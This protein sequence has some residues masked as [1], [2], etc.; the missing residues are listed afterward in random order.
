MIT[1]PNERLITES[2]YW[3]VLEEQNLMK[4]IFFIILHPKSLKILNEMKK[5]IFLLMISIIML[6]GCAGEQWKPVG[7]AVYSITDGVL[8]LKSGTLMYH[9]AGAAK[10]FTDFEMSGFA[11]T[12]PN[13]VAGIWFHSDPDR[14]GYEVVI[15][16]GPQDN[17]RKTG[18]LAAVRNLYKSMAKDNEWFPFT[19]TVRGKNIAIQINDRDV[20]CY[21]EPDKPYRITANSKSVLGQ[22]GFL[23]Y[24]YQGK[25]DFK[26]ISVKP[27]PADAAPSVELPKAIDEQIDPIIRLQQQ[28]FPVIDYHV[29]LKGWTME[30]AHA[31][32]MSYGINYGIAPNCGI[33][34]PITDDAGVR[35][36]VDST[37]NMPFYFGM[38]GEG[39]EWTTTFSAASRQLFDYVFTDA[40]TFI[41]HK[42][43]RT[44][45]WIPDET[46]ID[47]PVEKYMDLI[48][49]RTVT[50]LQ[51]EPIDI[52]VNPTLLPDQMQPDYDRLWTKERYEKVIKVLKDNNIAL[53]IN[54][55]YKI[56]NFAIIRAAK[57]AG[58]KITFGTNNAT[59][60]MGKLDYCLEAIKACGLTPND[61]WFPVNRRGK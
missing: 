53:E 38:Q 17:T 46:F 35:S 26:D 56:P 55:R 60:D 34:F 16:N 2:E 50:V 1:N 11:K 6:S 39:R 59:P 28:N 24:S 15:H 52:Y 42:G 4:S 57:A 27:L 47:I 5:S 18:S 8:T 44:R 36:Y 25:V 19:I 54:A 14:K 61:L 37:K 10:G 9:G 40:L 30:Q 23:L 49:D 51:S 7:E 13:T 3:A 21:T 12:E 45:L 32:S 20:V 22:G 31:L 48:V 58:I 41:D 33:G 43:R 29:H